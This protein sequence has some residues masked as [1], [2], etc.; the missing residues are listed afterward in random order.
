MHTSLL[1]RSIRSVRSTAGVT[2]IEVMIVV[3]II[4]LL[5][6]MAFPRFT[7]WASALRAKGAA[8][9]TAADI[10]YTRMAAVREGRTAALTV[11]GNTYTITVENTD[12][13]TFK[14]LRTVRIQD[15]YPGTTI[16]TTG[17][18]RIAFDSRGMRKDG[19]SSTVTL[20]RDGRSQR[21]QVSIIGRVIRD[22]PQ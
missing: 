9:Q 17:G 4:G 15:S 18:T 20:T 8:N 13:T 3:A 21:L 1:D 11:N 2:L 10:S 7:N 5:S 16:G 14:T 6:A 12:G 22:T 19:S